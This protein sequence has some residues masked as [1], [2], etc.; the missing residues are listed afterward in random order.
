MEILAWQRENGYVSQDLLEFS[1][2]TLLLLI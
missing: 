1:K 2:N